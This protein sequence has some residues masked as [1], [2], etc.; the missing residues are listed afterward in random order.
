M[1]AIALLQRTYAAFNARDLETALAAMHPDVTWPNGMEGG[2]VHGHGGIR[3]YWTRQ[4]AAIDPSVTPVGY[5]H[6]PDGR[7][8]VEVRQQ[9]RDRAGKPLF[10]GMVRHVYRFRDGLVIAMDIEKA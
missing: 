9:V 3:E 5:R 7:V 8:A 2:S 4:W 6:E 10:D 1:D